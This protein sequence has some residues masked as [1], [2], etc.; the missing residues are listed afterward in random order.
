[1]EKHHDLKILKSHRLFLS[2]WNYNIFEFIKLFEVFCLDGLQQGFLADAISAVFMGRL[3]FMWCV[4]RTAAIGI[5][6]PL[7]L[8]CQWWWFRPQVMSDSCDPMNCSLSGSSVHGILQARILEWVA[9]S[10]SKTSVM[11]PRSTVVTTPQIPAYISKCPVWSQL[12]PG[13]TF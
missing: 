12:C 5:L 1:M 8:K 7:L 3:F 13:V 4:L 11:L 6:A 2:M 9:I 10:F